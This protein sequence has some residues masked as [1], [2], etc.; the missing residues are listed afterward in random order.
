MIRHIAKGCKSGQD[1]TRALA[2]LH[3][4]LSFVR[5]VWKL[6]SGDLGLLFGSLVC[7]NVGSMRMYSGSR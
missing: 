2:D 4:W 6:V 5:F 1:R 3:L 7:D